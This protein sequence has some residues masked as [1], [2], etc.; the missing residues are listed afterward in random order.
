MAADPLSYFT[1]ETPARLSRLANLDMAILRYYSIHFY[2]KCNGVIKTET[3]IAILGYL[4]RTLIRARKRVLK[5]DGLYA[6]TSKRSLPRG[7]LRHWPS[8]WPEPERHQAHAIFMP[9][10]YEQRRLIAK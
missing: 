7:N 5:T 9:F 3:L 1:V 2:P 8:V 10:L 6:Y 4:L